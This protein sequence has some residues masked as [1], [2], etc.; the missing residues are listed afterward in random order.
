MT[1]NI[2]NIQLK[3]GDE[4]VVYGGGDEQSYQGR[5][6]RVKSVN[7]SGFINACAVLILDSSKISASSW[8]IPG[9]KDCPFSQSELNC[10]N[11]IVTKRK[12]ELA[13]AITIDMWELEREFNNYLKYE[14][15]K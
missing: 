4:F 14:G 2:K 6:W 9:G 5:V 8:F 3:T 15:I 12:P 1:T 11:Y 13:D 7:S 10:Y